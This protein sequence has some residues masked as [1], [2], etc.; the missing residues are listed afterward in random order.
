MS[1]LFVQVERAEE[2]T[3]REDDYFSPPKPFG[4]GLDVCPVCGKPQ[5]N[6]DRIRNMTDEKLAEFISGEARTFGEEYEGYM[7]A[8]DWLKEVTANDS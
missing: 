2:L 6:A 1:A 3:F 4:N 7:S 5:T 8:L